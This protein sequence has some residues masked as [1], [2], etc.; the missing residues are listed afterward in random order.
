MN[1]Q[2]LKTKYNYYLERYTKAID[3]LEKETTKENEKVEYLPY[4]IKCITNLNLL[5]SE[6]NRQKINFTYDEL[7]GG[8][9]L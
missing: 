1:P 3:F 2:E 8:F 7:S 9:K 4:A 5:I 6:F